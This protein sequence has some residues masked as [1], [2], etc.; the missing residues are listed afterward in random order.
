MK[1]R[2]KHLPTVRIKFIIAAAFS[3]AIITLFLMQNSPISGE[4]RA[5]GEKHASIH[6]PVTH[7]DFGIVKGRKSVS[8]RF[9]FYNRGKTLLLIGRIKAG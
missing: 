4:S 5:A 3:F 2:F 8:H 1:S 9:V 7:H 6:F